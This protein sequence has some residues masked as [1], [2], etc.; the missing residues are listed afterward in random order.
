MGHFKSAQFLIPTPPY[1]FIIENFEQYKRLDCRFRSEPFFSHP[2]GYKMCLLIFPNGAGSVKSDHVSVYV[3]I[4][5]GEYDDDLQWPF[6]GK[7]TVQAYN[8]A[9]KKWSADHTIVV[10]GV[11]RSREFLAES[12]V[13]CNKYLSHTELS[14]NYSMS[15]NMVRFRVIDVSVEVQ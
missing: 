11:C 9:V 8:R 2:G 15:T 5:R 13:G 7:I 6:N 4:L 1:Y 12:T 14:H 10:R 3:S